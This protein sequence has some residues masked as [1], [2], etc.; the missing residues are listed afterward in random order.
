[1]FVGAL[2]ICSFFDVNSLA[3]GCHYRSLQTEWLICDIELN[4]KITGARNHRPVERRVMPL[5]TISLRRSDAGSGLPIQPRRQSK[6]KRPPKDAQCAGDW[7][8]TEPPWSRHAR[9]STRPWTRLGFCVPSDHARRSSGTRL[10]W[11]RCPG[12]S[13]DTPSDPLD[14]KTSQTARRWW[15]AI[16]RKWKLALRPPERYVDIWFDQL[17]SFFSPSDCSD[18]VHFRNFLSCVPED[19][20]PWG[21][22]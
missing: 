8:R 16:C 10:A 13:Q 22:N 6:P 3:V 1:M 7:R 15:A 18:V 17:Q 2:D 12:S 19:E 5:I 20:N 9:Y 11:H 21:M 14:A 4:E